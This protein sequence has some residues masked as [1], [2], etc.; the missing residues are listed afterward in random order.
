MKVPAGIKTNYLCGE[1]L[2]TFIKARTRRGKEFMRI[3]KTAKNRMNKLLG[4]LITLSMT[5]IPLSFKNKKTHPSNENSEEFER[6]LTKI[7]L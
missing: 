4:L 5:F 7:E 1:L 2:Q 3:I 6:A